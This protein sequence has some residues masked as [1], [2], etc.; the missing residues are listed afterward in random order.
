M[1]CGAR[2][3]TYFPHQG[4]PPRV[5]VVAGPPLR[6]DPSRKREGR[7]VVRTWTHPVLHPVYLF[8]YLIAMR[9][10]PRQCAAPNPDPPE[11]ASREVSRPPL[12]YPQ[13]R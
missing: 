13:P 5:R 7:F 12:W 8:S 3:R 6:V 2:R 10:L 9:Y 11:R 1:K 4:A